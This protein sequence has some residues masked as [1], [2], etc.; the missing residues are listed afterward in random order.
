MMKK[1][2]KFLF[3][4]YHRPSA[5]LVHA[6]S[7]L[8][9]LFYNSKTNI[10]SER[11]M[12]LKNPPQNLV[13]YNSFGRVI[14]LILNF[15]SIA[16]FNRYFEKGVDLDKNI[17]KKIK[18]GND[19]EPWPEQAIHKFENSETKISDNLIKKIETDYFHS[20]NSI[21]DNKKFEDSEWW[22]NC[23]K[24]FKNLFFSEDKIN[25]NSLENFR[26]NIKTSAE[27]L[28]DKNFLKNT[29]SEKINKI[30]SIFLINL[31]HK[32][33][34]HVSLDILR[35]ASDSHVG[36]NLCL[37][38]R[39]QRINQRILRYA[40]Y[41]SQ[42][43]E[44][45]SLN[46]E[47][48]NIFLDIGGGYGGLSRIL[49]N[50]YD[51]SVCVIIELPELCLLS[52][53]FL[54]KNFPEKKIGTFSDFKNKENI[55]VKDLSDFDFVVLPQPFMEKFNEETF[56][57]IINTTSLGEMSDIMQDY[58]LQNIERCCKTYF[59]SVNRSKKRFEKYNS[60]GFYDFSFKNRWKVKVYK[61][62][63]TYHI[64]FLGKKTKNN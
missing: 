39:G 63:H 8:K 64:E 58:Y 40:Y 55:D 2:K 16:L 4:D 57:I 59:Y 41:A 29:N 9:K 50:V 43:K 25:V 45:T 13:F 32:L 62:T 36:K 47:N 30:K 10:F 17:N 12:L 46:V 15:F 60:R 56:D 34:E 19:E 14:I 6:I 23:R 31:Y 26:N 49:K 54:K 27:I 51:N 37:Y 44:N 11:V 28:N 42:I 22:K 21:R 7:L 20:V 3:E 53:Y 52:S 61:Y 1:L 35:M 33:S 38:Y 5:K 18:Q 48:K 24:E